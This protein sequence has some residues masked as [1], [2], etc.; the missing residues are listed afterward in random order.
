[1]PTSQQPKIQKASPPTLT[2]PQMVAAMGHPT[3]VHAIT[4]L[5]ER[6][7]CAAEIGK[8]IGR[9][10]GHV[11]YHLKKLTGL[12]IIEDLGRRKRRDSRRTAVFYRALVRPWF[13]T[14]AWKQVEADNKPGIT[15]NI[16]ALC[17]QD[18][19]AAVIAGTIHGDDNH[20]SRIPMI[21]DPPG[22]DQLVK[23]LD[24]A[25]E[26]IVAIQQEAATRMKQ[27][28]E[29]IL[30]KVHIIQFESPNPEETE[31]LAA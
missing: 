9:T 5:N 22:Y 15:S 19:A 20:I 30:T 16:L 24:N 4:V 18:I 13:D 25:T 29:T 6:V 12:G 10:S 28:G 23:Y 17:N 27:G 7:A 31:Q 21:L 26:E 3:R 11:S 8:E 14:D 1:M 2:N